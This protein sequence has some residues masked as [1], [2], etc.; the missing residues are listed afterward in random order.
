M[1]I[2]QLPEEAIIKK[3]VKTFLDILVLSMLNDEPMYGYKIMA[4]IH[5]E[6]GVL[7]SPGSLYPLLH[8]LEE[9]GLI[10]SSSHKGKIVYQISLKGKQNFQNIFNTYSLAIQKM[11]NFVKARRNVSP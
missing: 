10:E 3:H 1:E 6:F 2:Q 9:E 5:K 7:L 11:W 8:M 4:A